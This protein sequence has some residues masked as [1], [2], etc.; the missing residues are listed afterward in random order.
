M[1]TWWV[2]WLGMG[3][4][5]P[6]R[7]PSEV[8]KGLWVGGVPLPR[9]WRE[10]QVAGVGRVVTLLG[11]ATPAPWLRSAEA[12]L[13][14]P[15]RDNHPPTMDQLRVGCAFLDAG[16]NGA[17]ATLISCGAGIGRAATLYLAWRIATTGEPLHGALAALRQQRPIANPTPRQMES[18]RQWEDERQG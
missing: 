7:Q 16:R 17:P 3:N 4:E 8:E 10:L 15:V 1:S 18:L 9:R 2:Y 6:L 5:S 13:W 14:L 11:E 12:L